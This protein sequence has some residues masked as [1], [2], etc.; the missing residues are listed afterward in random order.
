MGCTFYE[1]LTGT[2]LFRAAN[3]LDLVRMM[4]EVLG[5]PQ[6]ESL[7]F[8]TNEH[9]LKYIQDMPPTPKRRPTQGIEYENP[10]ALDL[11]DK[12]LEFDPNKRITVEEALEHPYFA[13]LHEPSDEP[14]F[15]DKLDF[16]FE[17][18]DKFSLKDLKKM[19]LEEINIVNKANGEETYDV[20]EMSAGFTDEVMGEN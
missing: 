18:D 2:P 5:K 6:P 19:I 14:E 4:I 3:Y 20:E 8:I 7:K 12:C 1:L 10:H 11:I 13:D 17:H 9:A 16:E 15:G